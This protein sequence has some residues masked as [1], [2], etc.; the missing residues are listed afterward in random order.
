MLHLQYKHPEAEE[1]VRRLAGCSVEQM[2]GVGPPDWENPE[3]ND[4]PGGPCGESDEQ[5][6][7]LGPRP[8]EAQ[9][10]RNRS[11]KLLPESMSLEPQGVRCIPVVS[12][13]WSLLS[14]TVR[15]GHGWALSAPLRSPSAAA[16]PSQPGS[17]GEGCAGT[18]HRQGP[19]RLRQDY[20]TSE[21]ADCA[22]GHV[23]C[24]SRGTRNIKTKAPEMIGELNCVTQMLMPGA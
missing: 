21:G 14:P 3:F 10:E 2:W 20:R 6:C 11:W 12:V 5:K 17:E 24:C 13:M 1:G 22:F 19:G 9:W 18:Q 8:W 23:R 15:G 4:Q 7:Q 16:S